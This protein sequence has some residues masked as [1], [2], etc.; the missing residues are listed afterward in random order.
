MSS[1][2]S[3]ATY[4]GRAAQNWRCQTCG[5]I[6]TPTKEEKERPEQSEQEQTDHAIVWL[7]LLVGVILFFILTHI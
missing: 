4:A 2:S 6:V 7:L 3:A 5:A 1:V